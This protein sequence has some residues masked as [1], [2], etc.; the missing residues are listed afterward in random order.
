L[1]AYKRLAKL[2]DNLDRFAKRFTVFFTLATLSLAANIYV[3]TFAL[4]TA[5]F[6]SEPV[7]TV[8]RAIGGLSLMALIWLFCC[9]IMGI[10]Q[11]GD[12]KPFV[13]DMPREIVVALTMVTAVLGLALLLAVAVTQ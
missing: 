13:S 7:G 2:M 10:W 6:S 3:S 5:T 12:N 4:V 8:F 11:A 9:A 1:S